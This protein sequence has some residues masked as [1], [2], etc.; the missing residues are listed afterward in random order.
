MDRASAGSAGSD[1]S[2]AAPAPGPDADSLVVAAPA[3]AGRTV[4]GTAYV[5]R[6]AAC[7]SAA[8]SGVRNTT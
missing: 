6:P 1:T 3:G 4:G 7:S 2:A 5:N 8:C